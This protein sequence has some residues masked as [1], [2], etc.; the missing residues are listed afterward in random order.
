MIDLQSTNDLLNNITNG[1]IVSPS[2]SLDSKGLSG[3]LF[4]IIEDEEVSL[5]SEIT[6]H[7]VEDNSAVSDHIALAPER[8]TIRGFV[9][10]L[11]SLRPSAYSS[12]GG[13]SVRLEILSEYEVEFSTQ[14]I[15]NNLLRSESNSAANAIADDYENVYDSFYDK[16]FSSGNQQTAFNFFYSMWITKQL[17][18]VETPYNVFYDM[19]IESIKIIQPGES[20]LISDISITFKKIRTVET[21][22]SATSKYVD[23]RA[24]AML[25][26]VS[27]KGKS[28]GEEVDPSLLYKGFVYN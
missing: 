24:N 14:A 12:K 4:D 7:Y 10:E 26:D 18:T 11:K 22:I 27:E 20:K 1:V 19:A 8:F 23:G 16:N 3:F 28:Q 21:L 6:D 9:G 2:G 13:V 17:F 15:Q 5:N 25:S